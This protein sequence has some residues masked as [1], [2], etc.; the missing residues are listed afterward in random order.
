MTTIKPQPLTT[1]QLYALVCTRN[2]QRI[3]RTN[4]A[5][6]KAGFR[7]RATCSYCNVDLNAISSYPSKLGN[8]FCR[9]HIEQTGTGIFSLEEWDRVMATLHDVEFSKTPIV[10]TPQSKL[11]WDAIEAFNRRAKRLT[12][13]SP[14]ET[15]IRA[16]W[17]SILNG[18]YHLSRGLSDHESGDVP[19]DGSDFFLDI[20][21]LLNQLTSFER[22]LLDGA[23]LSRT[24]HA[25]QRSID[26]NV[27]IVDHESTGALQA[28]SSSEFEDPPFS[29]VDDADIP[30][31][32]AVDFK[33][34]LE[35]HD[36]AILASIR[37]LESW[38]RSKLQNYLERRG[39]MVRAE[40]STEQVR[41]DALEDFKTEALAHLPALK[42][43]KAGDRA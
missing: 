19:G 3:D 32:L 35:C 13:G 9:T 4:N 39:Y 11:G 22:A 18:I 33:L 30:W 25:L 41:A 34:S 28:Q 40:E 10:Q 1:F 21:G 38:D 24:I 17:V 8:Y 42:A 15:I 31:D 20:L 36:G 23:T 27:V 43:F 29:H 12:K 2:D 14:R 26:P 16:G 6:E 37:E 7:V 5:L